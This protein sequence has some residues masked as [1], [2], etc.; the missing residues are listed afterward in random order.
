MKKALFVLC[1]LSAT[2]AFAQIGASAINS[3]PQIYE[4][5][6][7]PEH[8]T[9]APMSQEQNVLGSANYSSA[10]GARPAS[11]FPQAE[12]VSLGAAARE[13]KKQHAQL[14]KSRFVWVNQ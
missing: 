6:S 11:D 3:Q 7:H 8:A 13:L 2:A 12:A 14:K 9:Y 1:L 10:Q 5:S 4:F